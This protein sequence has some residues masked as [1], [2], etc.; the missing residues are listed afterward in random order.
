MR[1]SLPDIDP[2]VRRLSERFGIARVEVRTL[3]EAVFWDRFS[4]PE[5]FEGRVS[6]QDSRPRE[7]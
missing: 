5:E 1:A 6:A 4:E 3:T 2:Q 7:T